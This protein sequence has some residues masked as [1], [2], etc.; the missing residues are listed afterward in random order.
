MDMKKL[1]KGLTLAGFL[2][3]TGNSFA[4]T[5]DGDLGATSTGTV[6]IAVDI[7]DLVRISNLV[8]MTGNVY[9]PGSAVTDSTTA[10]IYRNGASNYE[11][12]ATSLNGAGTNFFLDSGAN[13]V[14]YD[15]TFDDGVGGPTDL[16]NAVLESS[17][18]DA[19]QTSVDCMVGAGGGATIAISVP[20]NDA[21]FN[22]LAEVPAS[23]YTD[24]LTITVAPL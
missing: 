1:V 17:F 4:V 5:A 13:E 8:A 18:Q 3:F 6:D 19:N 7:S 16:N 20:E 21:V 9:T 2:A 15:V 10:C 11:I 22:G 14:I 12:T 24:V 23:N